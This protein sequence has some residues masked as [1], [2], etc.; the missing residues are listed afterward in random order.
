MTSLLLEAER[1]KLAVLQ[2]ELQLALEDGGSLNQAKEQLQE[3][4][5]AIS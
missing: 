2:K 4:I 1:R 5:I 3:L